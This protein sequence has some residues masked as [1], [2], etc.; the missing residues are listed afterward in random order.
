VVSGP[1][2][3]PGNRQYALDALADS[4]TYLARFA[5]E[6]APGLTVQIEPLDTRFHK[7]QSL[8]STAEAVALCD[9]VHGA[10]ERLGLCLDSAHMGLNVESVPESIRLA[11][12]YLTEFHLCNCCV[13]AANPLSG[14]LHIEPGPPGIFDVPDYRAFVDELRGGDVMLFVEILKPEGVPSARQLDR[15][16]R[17]LE[18]SMGARA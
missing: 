17:I 6:Q 12:R 13:D 11:R 14:D 8:G 5:R 1:R 2:P 10:G 4:L 7:R 15:C 9:A 3:Q 16:C 18:Q